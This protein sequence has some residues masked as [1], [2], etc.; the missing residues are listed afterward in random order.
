MTAA[1]KRDCSFD[2]EKLKEPF[3]ENEVE[4]RLSQVGETRDGKVW[5]QCLAYITSRA[6]MDRLDSVVG[7]GNWKVAYEFVGAS[8]VIGNLSIRIGDEWVTKQDGAEMTNI[9]SF[10]GGI[11]SALKRAGSVWGMGRYLYSLEATFVDI[12]DRNVKGANFG[13]TKSGKTFYWLPPKLPA[14]ALPTGTAKQ[15]QS[16]P[17]PVQ[18]TNQ[19]I[20]PS[21][22]QMN[23]LFSIAKSRNLSEASLVTLVSSMTGAPSLNEFQL[24]DYHSVCNS[25]LSG[26]YLEVLRPRQ[27]AVRS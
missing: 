2:L 9:E 22:A 19:I 10:K 20:Q 17:E 14:W 13:K 26:M 18:V 24:K 7:P 16:L 4:F 5:A 1:A 11:S 23:R 8:G 3:S 6:I 12:V 25:I 15:V 21:K 27:Q